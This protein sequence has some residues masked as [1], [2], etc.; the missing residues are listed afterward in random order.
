MKFA[1]GSLV[2]CRFFPKTVPQSGSFNVENDY[3]GFWGA[4]PHF[5]TSQMLK[6]FNCVAIFVHHSP[7][8]RSLI[9]TPAL[10]KSLCLNTDTTSEGSKAM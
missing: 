3:V 4:V 7:K 1:L 5:A 6:A 8:W 2:S 9:I 10:F